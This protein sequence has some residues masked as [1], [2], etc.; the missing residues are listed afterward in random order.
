MN[1]P[2][3]KHAVARPAGAIEDLP[4]VFQTTPLKAALH[5][6]IHEAE[7]SVEQIAWECRISPSYLYRSCLEG[8]SGCRFPLDLA[9]PLM[10]ATGDYRL[11]DHLN[12]ACDRASLK[13]PRVRRLKRS[14]PQVVNEITGNFNDAMAGVLAYFA[15]PDQAQTAEVVAKLR[16]HVSE[17]LMLTRAVAE[18]HQGEL[19]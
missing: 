16:R 19:L 14:D 12:G 18:C 9:V 13:L 11:L 1:A 15:K 3:R 8:E 10:T 7:K 6:T 5:R 4:V 2:I 17:V